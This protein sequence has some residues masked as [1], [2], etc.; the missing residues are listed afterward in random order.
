MSEFFRANPGLAIVAGIFCATLLLLSLIAIAMRRAGLSL[1]PLGWFAGFMALVLLPQLI[2]HS[3]NAYMAQPRTPPDSATHSA[4]PPATDQIDYSDGQKL[5]GAKAAGVI[6]IDGRAAASGILHPADQ[7][8]YYVLPSDETL[9]I[10]RFA[11]AADAQNA[12]G[13]FLAEAKLRDHGR[14]DDAG[15]FSAQRGANDFVYARAYA[16]LFTV[17]SGPTES[18]IT[19]LQAVAGFTGA[20][21]DQMMS[22]PGANQTDWLNVTLGKSMSTASGL[23]L[24]LVALGA[25]LLIVVGYFFK[26]IAWATRELPAADSHAVDAAALRA[27][28]LAVNELD[29]PFKIGAGADD[30]QLI[31]DWR[32]ADAKWIDHARI[33]GMRRLHRI[34]LAL[35]Q[36]AKKVRVTDY[37]ST[38]DWSAG[39]GGAKLDWHFQAGVVF[40]QYEHQRVFGLQLDEHGQFKPELS[41]AY[42]FNLQEMKAPIMRAVIQSGWS[43]QP[44]AWNAPAWLKW[45]T[46]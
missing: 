5:F 34:V 14:T 16:T 38:Y 32:Y 21:A 19:E 36:T 7:P 40:F 45:L 24:V 4:A 12:I 29:V 23:A 3:L 43:W 15:G 41:Y 26:G 1:K 31:A 37:Q 8:K 39:G 20:A 17:W 35:D 10:G 44:L 2:G 18:A 9:L 28:L 22:S 27:K 13:R 6:A 30:R 42:T 33:H 11:S 25:Y 46:E